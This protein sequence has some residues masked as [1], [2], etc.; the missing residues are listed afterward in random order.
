MRSILAAS[1]FGIIAIVP[2][3]S[4]QNQGVGQALQGLL[5]GNQAQDQAVRDA[6]ERGYQR[7]RDDEARQNRANRDD[8]RPEGRSSRGSGDEDASR[9]DRRR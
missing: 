7:G 5:G 1:L 9:N 6:Y 3:A 8:R 4:A 2:P